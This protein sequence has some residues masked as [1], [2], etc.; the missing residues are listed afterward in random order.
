[1]PQHFRMS[2]SEQ[3]QNYVEA[4]GWRNIQGEDP[5]TGGRVDA[6]TTVFADDL[7]ELHL[8][9]SAEDAVGMVQHHTDMMTATLR[10]LD[11]A[12]NVDKAEHVLHLCGVEASEATLHRVG[13]RS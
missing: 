13:L 3:V 10:K 4:K 11:M 5:L 7:A 2:Y 9:S 8:V 1:M 6:G 12:Q